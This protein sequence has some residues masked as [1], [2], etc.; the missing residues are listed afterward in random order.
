MDDQ[1]KETNT[2]STVVTNVI[3]VAGGSGLRMGGDFPK[4]FIAIGG[5]PILMRTIETFYQFDK[6]IHIVLVMHPSY[7]DY[8]SQLCK[9][10]GFTILH[11]VID[12]G[13]TRFDSVKNGLQLIKNGLIAVHDGV[14]PFAS[15]KLIQHC[16]EEAKK[17]Q[18]VIPTTE[19]IDSLREVTDENT[20][21]IVDRSK[22]RNVQTPQ[23]FDCELLKNAYKQPYDDRFTDDASVVE[24]L[25]QKIHLVDGER[26]N[27]KI[28]TPFDLSL[29]EVILNDF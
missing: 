22:Y 4:Q 1:F 28:T 9:S 2:G 15:Q 24:A 7:R 12:G 10:Y 8:W 21:K 14:R 13:D 20:N 27:I 11:E 6:S 19:L 29:A 5:R 25:G 23:V 17:F 18:A 26:I 16:F 3:I